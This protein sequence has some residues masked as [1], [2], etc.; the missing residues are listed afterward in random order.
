VNGRRLTVA[1]PGFSPPSYFLLAV[2]TTLPEV[3]N[4]RT[5]YGPLAVFH[6]ES[7]AYPL[8]FFAAVLR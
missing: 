7:V 5:V 4:D 1:M 2:S 8:M 3:E 6:S